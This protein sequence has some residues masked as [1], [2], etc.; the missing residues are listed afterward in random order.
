MNAST[1]SANTGA[2]KRSLNKKRLSLV[3]PSSNQSTNLGLTECKS[4]PPSPA[5]GAALST[6]PSNEIST[7]INMNTSAVKRLSTDAANGMSISSALRGGMS[8][9]RRTSL[10]KLNMGLAAFPSSSQSTSSLHSKDAN[11][12]LGRGTESLNAAM[13]ANGRTD[14]FPYELGPVEIVPGLYLGS[15]QVRLVLQSGFMGKRLCLSCHL[16]RT[17]K[18]QRL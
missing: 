15:E 12:L 4:C 10:P 7:S 17:L 1:A 8:M 11:R 18:I 6:Q 13:A 9:R 2:N 3:V 16:S 14:S 5:E